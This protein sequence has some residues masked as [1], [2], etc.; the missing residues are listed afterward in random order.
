VAVQRLSEESS[1]DSTDSASPQ[2]GLEDLKSGVRCLEGAAALGH[3]GAMYYLALLHLQGSDRLGIPKCGDVEF[4]R[5]L[6]LACDEGQHPDA[7]FLRGHCHFHGD[8]TI[9]RSVRRALEDFL[10]AADAGHADA[11]VSAGAILFQGNEGKKGVGSSDEDDEDFVSRDRRRAF[12]LYQH[13]GELGSLDGWRNV[14]ACYATGQGV[15]Q[16]LETAQYIAHTMLA[17]DREVME[18]AAAD[19]DS[20]SK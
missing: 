6:N 15:P 14:V 13:A 1:D 11:A 9:D 2:P 5:R 16:S 8:H 18:G 19:G 17:S 7:W 4:A 20:A 10:R 12:E 3:G